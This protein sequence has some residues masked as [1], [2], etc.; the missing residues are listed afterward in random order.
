MSEDVMYT[1]LKRL[2]EELLH[3]EMRS[4][5]RLSRGGLRVRRSTNDL[6]LPSLTSLKWLSEDEALTRAF[7][8]ASP[9]L[10][11]VSSVCLR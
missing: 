7:P 3:M 9:A 5:G 4:P 2:T 6:L 10:L 11:I 8:L 1:Q